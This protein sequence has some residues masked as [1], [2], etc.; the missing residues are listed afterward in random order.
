MNLASLFALAGISLLLSATMLRLLL[1]F[2]VNKKAAYTL[3]IIVFVVSFLPFSGYTLNQYFRGL[4]NDLSV[5]TLLLLVFY[6]IKPAALSQNRP[7]FFTIALTGICFYPVALGLGPLDPY[8]SGYISNAHGII[9]AFLFLLG[10][11]LL[12]TYCYIKGYHRLLVC[13][14]ASLCAH[15][16]GLLESRNV[17]DYLLDPL[18]FFYALFALLLQWLAPVPSALEIQH[19]KESN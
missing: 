13:L 19:K 11:A 17:W 9:P 4:F 1:W 3:S 15:Q 2:R 8:A 16:A 14:I 12:M 6:F 5:T 10:L 18:I 7:I